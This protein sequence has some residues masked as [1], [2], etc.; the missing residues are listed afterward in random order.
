MATEESSVVAA[1][2]NAA[3]FW[4]SRGGFKTK[5]LGTEK[6]GQVH[7]SKEKRNN[8]RLFEQKT[9]ADRQYL[10]THR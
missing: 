3:K 8:S 6:I 9:N 1:A 4:A 7:Y 2:C 10:I 5:I